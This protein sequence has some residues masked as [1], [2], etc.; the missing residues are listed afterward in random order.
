MAILILD[1]TLEAEFRQSRAGVGDDRL[2]EVWEGVSV[3]SP[4]PNDEHQDIQLNLAMS[5][6][7]VV[8]DSGLGRVRAGVNVSDRAD[9]WTHNYRAPDVVVY[10]HTNPAV[11]HGTFWRGG[12]DFAAE[13]VSPGEDAYA[14]L[15]FYAAVGTRELLVVHR[16]PWALELFVLVGGALVLAGRSELAT[17]VVLASG[18]T[19]L[20]FRLAAG[21]ERPAIEVSH[22]ASGRSWRV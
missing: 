15:G 12:P 5:L 6:A 10:L 20:T 16:D 11:N 13:I 1:P 8:R 7:A 17:P 3:V 9:G 2:D 22:A 21:E 19:G 4:L 14:K 18:A